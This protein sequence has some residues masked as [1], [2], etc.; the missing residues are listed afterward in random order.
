MTELQQK[1]LTYLGSCVFETKENPRLMPTKE[2]MP[3]L[4]MLASGF[5]LE[6]FIMYYYRE[7]LPEDIYYKGKKK[8]L[9]SSGRDMKHLRTLAKVESI[10]KENNIDYALLKG[11][12]LIKNIYPHSALR[13]RCDVDLL[14]REQDS[15]RAFELFRQNEWQPEHTN[16][17]FIDKHMPELKREGWHPVEIHTKLFSNDDPNE[18]RQL[19]ELIDD[20]NYYEVMLANLLKH[21]LVTHDFENGIK[22]LFDVGY[23]L[24]TQNIDFAK[25]AKLEKQFYNYEFMPLFITSF[26]EFFPKEIY[27]QFSDADPKL[28]NAL[29]ELLFMYIPWS[30]IEKE[31]LK[32][33]QNLEG[34]GVKARLLEIP[35]DMLPS[36]LSVKFKV[37]SI[38]KIYCLYPYYLVRL[39]IVY[40]Q[41]IKLIFSTKHANDNKTKYLKNIEI[42]HESY[43][44]G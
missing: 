26:K 16:F 27:Q 24:K 36:N 35:K 32:R 23:L 37:E 33:T 29:R 11:N 39:F 43:K 38:A 31:I 10:L 7:L 17:D 2:E 13:Y 20:G 21:C 42:V 22:T 1:L 8:Y 40:I 28:S 3:A 15:M 18:N 9:A 44:K 30:S 4:F 12:F 6:K 25:L 14:V 19:W 34:R 5:G 41:Y